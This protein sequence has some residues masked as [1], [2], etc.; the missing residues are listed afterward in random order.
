MR[1]GDCRTHALVWYD[2]MGKVPGTPMMW[3]NAKAASSAP[4]RT[5]CV[6]VNLVVRRSLWR[7]TGLKIH[8]AR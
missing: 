3:P 1:R 5:E 2:S 8:V 4:S 7:G 6:M